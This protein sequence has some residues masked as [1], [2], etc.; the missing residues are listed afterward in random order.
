LS[1][2]CLICSEVEIKHLLYDNDLK[3]YFYPCTCKDN[4][5]GHLHSRQELENGKDMGTCPSCFLII[6][7]I[8][9]KDQYM[10]RET[11]PAPFT[12]RKFIKC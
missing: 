7:V 11:D 8:D 5:Y 10:C 4:L 12:N 2:T 1:F 6:K 9:D 3:M